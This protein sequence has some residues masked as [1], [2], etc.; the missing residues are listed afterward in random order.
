MLGNKTWFF[1]LGCAVVSLGTFMFLPEGDGI[2]RTDAADVGSGEENTF[3]SGSRSSAPEQFASSNEG[4]VLKTQRE[5]ISDASATRL[6]GGAGPV[7]YG[8][9]VDPA[10]ES[11]WKRLPDDAK[12][13]FGPAIDAMDPRSRIDQ[14]GVREYGVY[15]DPESPI[16]RLNVDGKVVEFGRFVD[17]EDP[18]SWR[19]QISTPVEYGVDTTQDFSDSI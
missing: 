15:I 10:D 7:D 11:T 1:A 18:Y 8:P 4:S 3:H 12:R 9:F 6:I 16:S 13:D 17:P 2:Y 14:E 5:Q 19:P